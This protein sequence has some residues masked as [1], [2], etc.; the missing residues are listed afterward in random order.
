LLSGRDTGQ[1]NKGKV[2]EVF[3]FCSRHGFHYVC[4]EL[5]NL[6]KEIEKLRLDRQRLSIENQKLWDMLERL[7]KSEAIREAPALWYSEAY[8]TAS[9]MVEGRRKYQ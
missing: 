6:K 5:E 7:V 8:I 9:E 2:N 3:A 4:M 1:S